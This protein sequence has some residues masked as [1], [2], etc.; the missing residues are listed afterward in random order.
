MNRLGPAGAGAPWTS[1]AAADCA[2]V[3]S[4]TAT[5]QAFRGH[6]DAVAA[7]LEEVTV[8]LGCREGL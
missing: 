7:R 3:A 6:G 8:A 1:V 4:G 5:V 2:I